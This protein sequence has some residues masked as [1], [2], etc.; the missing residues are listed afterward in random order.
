MAAALGWAYKGWQV[1]NAMS[2]LFHY[3]Q[4]PKISINVRIGIDKTNSDANLK[5]KKKRFLCNVV[6]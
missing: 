1:V 2:G 6:K 4:G 3:D 5:K